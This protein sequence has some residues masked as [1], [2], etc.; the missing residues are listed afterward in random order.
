MDLKGKLVN[1]LPYNVAKKHFGI[2]KD[3]WD[4][5]V[6]NNPHKVTEQGG[7]HIRIGGYSFYWPIVA[8]EECYPFEPIDISSF[9]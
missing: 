9:M 1:I 4:D 6:L 2:H 5:V 7:V 3:Y 8:V